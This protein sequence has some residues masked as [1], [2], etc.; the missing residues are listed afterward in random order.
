MNE[1]TEYKDFP[2]PENFLINIFSNAQYMPNLRILNLKLTSEMKDKV[3]MNWPWLTRFRNTIQQ[4]AKVKNIRKAI[5]CQKKIKGSI[6][7]CQKCP[8]SDDNISS[9]MKWSG[10]RSFQVQEWTEKYS[11]WA[12]FFAVNFFFFLPSS[13]VKNLH[14]DLSLNTFIRVYSPPYLSIW[15]NKYSKI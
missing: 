15:W 9:L 4:V 1:C 13:K 6:C 7:L 12:M 3:I 11:L 5:W 10:R 14:R 8:W 2:E